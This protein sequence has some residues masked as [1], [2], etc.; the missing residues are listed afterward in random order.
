MLLE[1]KTQIMRRR[2][3]RA[4]PTWRNTGGGEEQHPALCEL[5]ESKVRMLWVWGVK[6]CAAGF[7]LTALGGGQRDPRASQILGEQ[8]EEQH[9]E[10]GFH[11]F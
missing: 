9:R 10:Q 11:L 1:L 3:T 4:S 6:V 8:D 2:R 7:V 5:A